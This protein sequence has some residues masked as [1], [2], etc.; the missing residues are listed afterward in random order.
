M[1]ADG[2]KFRRAGPDE[3]R[4]LL[5]GAALKCL[6]HEGHAGIS[7]RRIAKQAGVSV[8]LLNHHFGGID[9]LIAEAYQKLSLD[10]TDSLKAEVEKAQT[11]AERLDA[12]LIGSFSSR[13]L[14]QAL[15]GVWVVFWSL[16]RHSPA[17]HDA[18]EQGYGAYRRLVKELLGA[19]AAEEGFVIDD[20]R[21]AAIGLSA[22][23]DGLWLEWCLNP[24]TFSAENGLLICRRWVV[25]LRRGA[26]SA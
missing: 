22:T 5:V 11:A 3:R 23:L 6:S 13:I 25:G 18:H 7:V 14:D 15:L 17:V 26:F 24:S 4:D 20:V 21:L 10:L 16:V 1:E 2:R 19:L 12:F 8:G 9:A